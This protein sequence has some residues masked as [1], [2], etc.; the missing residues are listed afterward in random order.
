MS[1][2]AE[3]PDPTAQLEK[4][5]QQTIIQLGSL[6]YSIIDLKERIEDLERENGYLEAEVTEWRALSPQIKTNSRKAQSC[7]EECIMFQE[8]LGKLIFALEDAETASLTK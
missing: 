5:S 7:Q 2:Q 3:T 1:N 6:G 8:K 4:T